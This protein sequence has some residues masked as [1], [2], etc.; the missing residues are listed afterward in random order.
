VPVW[1]DFW[2]GEERSGEGRRAPQVRA[3]CSDSPTLSERSERSE[4]SEFGG[5][6]FD[7]STTAQSTPKATTD[8]A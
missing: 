6:T 4:R 8:P 3:S 1:G 5:A 7:A 2:V